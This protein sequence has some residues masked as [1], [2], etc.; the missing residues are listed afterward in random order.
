MP[1]T[2]PAATLP[3][4]AHGAHALTGH[5]PQLRKEAPAFLRTLP[6]LG[7][8]VRIRV[9]LEPVYVVN[10]PELARQVLVG[11]ARGYVK[12]AQFEIAA[13]YFGHG[14]ATAPGG[15]S[16]LAQRRMLQPAFHRARMA[17]YAEVM[18]EL[19]AREARRW[20]HGDRI[21]VYERMYDLALDVLGRTLFSTSLGTRVI[22]E[23]RQCLPVLI[24]DVQH[25]VT[26]LAPLPA[27]I[28]TPRNRRTAAAMARLRAATARVIADYRASGT[29]QGDI[30]SSL[31]AARDEQTRRGMTDQQ[32]HDEIVTLVVG[33]TETTAATLSWAFHLLSTDAEAEG[34][35]HAEVDAVVRGGVVRYADLPRM[36]VLASVV[37]E[38]LRLYPTLLI[39]TRK[40]AGRARLGAYEVPSGAQVW[41]NMHALHRD[42]R[43]FPEPDL[44]E[45]GRWARGAQGFRDGTY[46]PFGAGNRKCIGDDFALVEAAVVLGTL[47][48]RWRLRHGAARRIRTAA[49]TTVIPMNLPMDVRSRERT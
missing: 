21:R 47:A 3:P 8:V 26:T 2:A 32:V 31:L 38:T 14:L 25:R 29:D 15:A 39:I 20:R 6:A 1:D 48:G 28:P 49:G 41:V 27:A 45:P 24:K 46:L 36:P 13:R 17:G 34:E 12:G 23:F 22:G 37:H 42:P 40:T 10:T 35:L 30:L 43:V 18:S 19:A 16:H 7:D 9:G 44:F 5:L 33:G 4:L 11:D